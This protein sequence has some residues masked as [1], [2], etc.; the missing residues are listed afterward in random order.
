[1]NEGLAVAESAINM[2]IWLTIGLQALLFVLN[3]ASGL[4]NL[5]K[6]LRA[7]AAQAEAR[8]A[9]PTLAANALDGK[10]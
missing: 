7:K 3:L 5:R 8:G 1:M 4:F 10:P 9:P 6:H 2:M